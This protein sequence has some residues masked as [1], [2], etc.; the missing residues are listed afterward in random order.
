MKEELGLN[1]FEGRSWRG[2]HH[3]ACLVMLA[4]GFLALEQLREK[5][6]P[7]SPGTK[8]EPGPRITLPAIRR[9]LQRLLLPLAKPDCPYCRSHRKLPLVA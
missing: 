5:E 7:A 6:A 2:F 4:Y 3:H 8:S 1:H 9:A